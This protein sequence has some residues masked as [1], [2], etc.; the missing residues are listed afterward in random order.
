MFPWQ[1]FVSKG[2]SSLFGIKAV[3][4]LGLKLLLFP[5]NGVKVTYRVAL[6]NNPLI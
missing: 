5:N 3:S 4:E 6:K 2:G 1:Q